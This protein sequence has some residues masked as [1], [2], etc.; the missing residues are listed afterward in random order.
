MPTFT[1]RAWAEQ[2]LYDCRDLEI[3]ADSPEDAA[4]LYR[5]A[6]DAL[7]AGDEAPMQALSGDAFPHTLDPEDIISGDS[8]FVLL[9]DDGKKLRDVDPDGDGSDAPLPGTPGGPPAWSEIGQ[10]RAL[11]SDCRTLIAEW[12]EVHVWGDDPIGP[13]CNGTTILREIA[14]ALARPYDPAQEPAAPPPFADIAIVCMWAEAFFEQSR[15][16]DGVEPEEQA[17][18][19]AGNEALDSV[20]AWLSGLRGEA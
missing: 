13:D 12:Q 2:T 5:D 11:L 15:D 8:G 18:R 7:E 4:R 19:D 17:Q 20:N 16:D 3:E 1:I 10:L 6:L 9:D 14:A